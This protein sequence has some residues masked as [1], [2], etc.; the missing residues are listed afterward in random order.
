MFLRTLIVPDRYLDSVLLMGLAARLRGLAGVADAS[1]VMGTEANRALLAETGLLDETATAAAP[2]DVIVSLQLAEPTQLPAAQA[3]L[4]AMLAELTRTDAG[5]GGGAGD[6]ATPPRTLEEALRQRP[7]ASVAVISLPGGYVARE[8]RRALELGLH[9]FIFSDNVPLADEVALK[10]LG[11]ERGLLVMGPDCGTAILNGLALGFAN[12]VARGPVGIIGASGTGIQELSCLLHRQ[13]I[14]IH[15]AIGVGGRDLSAAVGGSSMLQAL[16][17]LEADPACLVIVLVSKPPHPEV[18]QAV[19]DRAAACAK[20]CVICFLGGDPGQAAQRNLPFA[21]R[22]DLAAAMTRAVLAGEDPLTVA[23]APLPPARQAQAT[24]LAADLGAGRRFVRGLFSGGTLGK[25]ALLV[26]RESLP[27]YRTNL[28]EEGPRALVGD[29]RPTDHLILD[30]G[31]DRYTRGRPHPMIDFGLRCQ[32]LQQELADPSCAVLLLD[33]VLGYGAHPDPAGELATAVAGRLQPGGPVL[34][35]CVVGTEN[36][37]Q[38]R[39]DQVRRLTA[40]GFQVLDTNVEAARMAAAILVE[41]Q[42]RNQP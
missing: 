32:R 12:R 36:D 30:L 5:S 10:A 26:L 37:P 17:I 39:P 4:E 2:G 21:R 15:Q 33:V 14:G 38:P 27:T 24:T 19:L 34:L 29:D 16:A 3:A 25:E 18:A 6:A 1:A 9:P 7:D 28:E 8:A 23:D 42:R 11:R 35:A 41:L 20:P 40:A 22:L 13:G 31:D